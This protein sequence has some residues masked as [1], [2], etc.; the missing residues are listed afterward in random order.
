MNKNILSI[1]DFSGRWPESFTK[2][3]YTVYTLDIKAPPGE[4]LY[5]NRIHIE[6]NILDFNYHNFPKD[7]FDV[8]LAAIICTDFALAGAKHFAKKDQDG[9]TAK[10]ID[11]V[12]KTLEIIDYFK[13]RVWAIENPRTRMHKLV[14]ELGPPYFK[15]QPWEFGGWVSPVEDHWKETWLWGSFAIPEKKP[16]EPEPRDRHGF[17]KM[18]QTTGGSSE[19]TKTIRSMTP[20]GFARAFAE[21]NA[22]KE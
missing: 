4:F 10:S 6:S 1:F 17:G 14:P 20:R 3:E 19:R 18:F 16:V 11:L 9:R 21:A 22:I 15:F 5:P 12:N 7:Y 2:Y 13:P 8:I